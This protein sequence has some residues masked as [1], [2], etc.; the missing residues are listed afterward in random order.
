MNKGKKRAIAVC[1][2]APTTYSAIHGSVRRL[3]MYIL[4]AWMYISELGTYILCLQTEPRAAA[5][6][7]LVVVYHGID[8]VHHGFGHAEVAE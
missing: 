2:I 8:K 7:L 4:N 3:R 5:G 6:R 1:A